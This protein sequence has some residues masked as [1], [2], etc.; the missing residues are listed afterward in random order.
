MLPILFKM[1]DTA[2]LYQNLCVDL[3]L[4]SSVPDISTTK[5][6]N[7]VATTVKYIPIFSDVDC[8]SDFIIVLLISVFGIMTQKAIYA[9]GKKFE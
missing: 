1:D 6:Y 9:F 2:A 3:N 5:M 8:D 4:I 7:K